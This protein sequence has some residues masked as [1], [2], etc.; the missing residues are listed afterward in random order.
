MFKFILY[1][2]LTIA[3]LISL[4]LSNS[5]DYTI[6]STL[7][8][9]LLGHL[10][11]KT[12]SSFQDLTDTTNWKK[13]Q[14]KLERGGFIDK[15]TYIRIS[16]AYLFRI[17]IDGKYLL[18]KNER[19][20]KKFQPVGG[21]Y[22]MNDSEKNYLSENFNVL[23]DDKISIDESSRNDYRL[24]IKNKYLRKFVKRFDNNSNRET[25]ENL[26]REFK[27]EL[28]DKQIVNWKE[29]KY[30]VCGRHVTGIIY[31]KHFQIYELLL[32]D[33]VEIMLTP[34]QEV[35]L[36]KMI[37]NTSDYYCFANENE[38]A[39]LG[40]DAKR[41]VLEETI[42]DHSEKI[43]EINQESLIEIPIA[44]KVYEVKL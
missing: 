25:F 19:N 31:S 35:D 11:Q 13:S 34:K 39:S 5:L 4:I 28:V 32:A 23:D 8:G 43:L 3:S 29:I 24:R 17:K 42:A 9:L 33:V 40:V 18:V 6:I 27:E 44:K 26:S 12:K 16:F 20:T 37:T 15:D 30:K 36:R 38:I 10:E 2:F 41:G 22:K 7:S 21:V 1:L 14:R